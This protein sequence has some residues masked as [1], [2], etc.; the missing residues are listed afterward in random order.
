MRDELGKVGSKVVRDN[1]A[2]LTGS[3][4]GSSL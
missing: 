3:P 2:I 4:V 1:W